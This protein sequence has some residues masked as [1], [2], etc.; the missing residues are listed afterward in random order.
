M[1]SWSIRLGSWSSPSAMSGLVIL[2]AS[3]TSY[4][5]ISGVHKGFRYW[6]SCKSF[7]SA[8]GGIRKKEPLRAAVFPFTVRCGV[9]AV[10]LIFSINIVLVIFH[11]QAQACR[12]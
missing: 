9:L 1:A 4:I 3:S 5:L 12:D 2:I 7:R 8:S 10:S 6:Q 11:F